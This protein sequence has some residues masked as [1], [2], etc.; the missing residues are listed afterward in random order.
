MTTLLSGKEV[1]EEF[2]FPYK[3][4]QGITEI[5][6]ILETK[7]TK[8]DKLILLCGQI[9]PKYKTEII[10]KKYLYYF[11]V[12]TYRMRLSDGEL[13]TDKLFDDIF[14]QY[15]LTNDEIKQYKEKKIA[16]ADILKSR[17]DGEV[18]NVI[19]NLFDWR[20]KLKETPEDLNVKNVIKYPFCI[21][22]NYIPK[23]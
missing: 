20:Y 14:E 15:E 7:R 4:F 2:Y 11:N 19:E 10:K 9:V 5:R 1:E 23:L 3:L 12:K 6:K 16:I 22:K 21:L 8:E 13:T 18:K 17:N